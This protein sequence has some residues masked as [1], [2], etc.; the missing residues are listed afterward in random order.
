MGTMIELPAIQMRRSMQNQMRIALVLAL[1]PCVCAGALA[2]TATAP[3]PA[4]KASMVEPDADLSWSPAAGIGTHDVYFGEDYDKVKTADTGSPVYRGRQTATTFDPGTLDTG[5]VY[6]WR[7]DE[8]DV[9]TTTGSV[10]RFATRLAPGQVWPLS[11]G[12]QILLD[13]GLQIGT[14][15]I[16][17]DNWANEAWAA[18]KFTTPDLSSGRPVK[19]GDPW[20]IFGAT[21]I[22][23][24]DPYI[25][26]LIAWAYRDEQ[27][28]SDP[29]QV[30]DAKSWIET[31]RPYLPNTLLYT[32]Q[33]SLSKI[34]DLRRYAQEVRPDMVHCDAY[35][36]A[37]DGL[38][39]YYKGYWNMSMYRT[40]GL[41]GNDGT[42]TTP[43]PYGIWGQT[44]RISSIDA[45]Q[46]AGSYWMPS[47][48]E[49][50]L[51]MFAAW[52]F[53]FKHYTTFIYN[54]VY[55]N[56]NEYLDSPFFDDGAHGSFQTTQYPNW[57]A[58]NQCGEMNRESLNLGPALVRLQSTDVR[59]L[60]GPPWSGA[61]AIIAQYTGTAIWDS[62]ADPYIKG[63]TP[64][65]LGSVNGGQPGDVLVGYFKP[66][67]ADLESGIFGGAENSLGLYFMVTNG[68]QN[69]SATASQ[70]AQSIRLDF[71]FGGEP[72]RLQRLSRDT[73]LVESVALV[74][75]AGSRFHLDFQ[76]DGGTGDLFRFVKP[77]V[78]AEEALRILTQ[79]ESAVKRWYDPCTFNVVAAGGAPPLYYSWSKD[80]QPLPGA[81]DSS[82]TLPSI[83]E[84]DAGVYTVEVF[85]NNITPIVSEPATLTVAGSPT[86]TLESAGEILLAAALLLFVARF[87]SVPQRG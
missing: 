57:T 37:Y 82:L 53:G 79:P 78:P 54:D 41:E 56:T 65:N 71:D 51:N 85:D 32:N 34:D 69:N 26:G 73:G 13:R 22:A 27:D 61:P 50:R 23:L 6:F 21:S 20:S 15:I 3:S 87:V 2:D 33:G 77:A 49:M 67:R 63:I 8:V 44:F 86:P 40:L 70:A 38:C 1:V 55:N 16:A 66:L 10:W 7:I 29:A 43:I 45:Q 59:I 30:A 84:S 60:P 14:L 39:I 19:A 68:L 12:H 18:S 75:D 72:V 62:N 4:D 36:W 64:T 52:T 83:T 80:G 58:L 9:A 25:P 31:Y 42:G 46:Q 28:I 5:K 24:D 74:H 35:P 76:L 11:K 48:S 47:E 17:S 81:S